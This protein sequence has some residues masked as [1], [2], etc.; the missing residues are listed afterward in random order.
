MPI[1]VY[2]LFIAYVK[3]AIY[4]QLKLIYKG[5]GSAAHFIQKV[6]LAHFTKIYFLVDD[7]PLSIKLKHKLNTSF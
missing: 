2:K 3:D 5:L 4:S 6:H 1:A 7:T